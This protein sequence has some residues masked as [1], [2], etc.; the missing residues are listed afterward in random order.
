MEC[1]AAYSTECGVAA[2]MIDDIASLNYLSVSIDE[3]LRS[4]SK[5][6]FQLGFASP[7]H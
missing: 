2:T 3:V 7:S 4:V 5:I 1:H 6:G